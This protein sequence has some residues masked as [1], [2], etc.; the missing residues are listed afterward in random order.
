MGTLT[1]GKRCRHARVTRGMDLKRCEM[2]TTQLEVSV[3]PGKVAV[4]TAGWCAVLSHSPEGCNSGQ[5][6][7][8]DHREVD[9]AL[10]ART[11][12]LTD[13]SLQ[14][15]PF[16]LLVKNASAALPRVFRTNRRIPALC[17]APLRRWR[18]RG[19]SGRPV[20]RPLLR[21]RL[22]P[23]R[24]TEVT[25]LSGPCV[26]RSR[27]ASWHSSWRTPPWGRRCSVRVRRR[28]L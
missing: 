26:W 13:V 23:A 11:T 1:I 12:I 15:P 3:R 28:G 5:K 22:V 4:N 17:S 16:Q 8:E 10:K 2:S 20:R 6:S 14:C 18:L 27:G 24:T 19:F 21:P 7:R 9:R 25:P